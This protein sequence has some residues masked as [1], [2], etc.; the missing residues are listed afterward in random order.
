MYR[1][2]VREQSWLQVARMLYE[3]MPSADQQDMLEQIPGLGELDKQS[4]ITE[5]ILKLVEIEA[6]RLERI[7]KGLPDISEE[8]ISRLYGG[9]LLYASLISSLVNLKDQPFSVDK[10]SA[11]QY[12]YRRIQEEVRVKREKPLEVHVSEQMFEKLLKELKET[13]INTIPEE[14][15]ENLDEVLGTKD[16]EGFMVLIMG[17]SVTCDADIKDQKVSFIY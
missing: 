2:P 10:H 4:Q 16:Y 7:G 3:R 5:A 1:I 8:Q 11:F 9:P 13:K 14:I 12:I 17:C 15:Q 6:F